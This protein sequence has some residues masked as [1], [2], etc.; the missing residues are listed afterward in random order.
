[1]LLM[2]NTVAEVQ[3]AV[4][5]HF[6]DLPQFSV[7]YFEIVDFETFEPIKVLDSSKQTAICTA[8]YLED[9]RLID[10]VVF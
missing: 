5:N 8:N 4:Q 1:M 6:K 3:D 7:E 10:N 2:G 9:V